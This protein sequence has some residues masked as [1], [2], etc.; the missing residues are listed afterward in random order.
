MKRYTQVILVIF[1]VLGL[2]WPALGEL[3]PVPTIRLQP[4]SPEKQEPALRQKVETVKRHY[5]Y[6][7]TSPL[8]HIVERGAIQPGLN[9]YGASFCMFQSPDGKMHFLA[10]F[11]GPGGWRMVH[12]NMSDASATMI[13]GNGVVEA[14]YC[15]DPARNVMY[16]TNKY[17]PGY[18]YI[19]NLAT[20]QVSL[21]AGPMWNIN[22]IIKG[23]DGM[24]WAGSSADGHIASY[25][26]VTRIFKTDWPKAH[27]DAQYIESLGAD[28]HYIYCGCRGKSDA[29]GRFLV[30][31]D[32]ANPHHI[33]TFNY[34]RGDVSANV[35]PGARDGKYYYFRREGKKNNYRTSY[36]A[37]PPVNGRL[38]QVSN[39]HM[40]NYLESHCASDGVRNHV[41]WER[42]Y[43]WEVNLDKYLPME[44]TQEYSEIKFRHPVGL[45]PWTTVSVPYTGP[46]GE[47]P[48]AAIIGISPTKVVS[49]SNYLVVY[50]YVKNIKKVKGQTFI[51]S[52]GIMRYDPTGEIYLLGYPKSTLRYDP[53]KPWTLVASNLKPYSPNDPNRP[54]PYK[55]A[56]VDSGHYHFAADYDANGLVWIAS[57]YTRTGSDYGVLVWYNPVDGTSGTVPGLEARLKLGAIKLRALVATNHRTKICV[58][59]ADG[60]IYVID[61]ATKTLEHTWT[62]RPGLFDAIIEVADDN[63][64]VVQAAINDASG[65]VSRVTKLRISTGDILFDHP[66]GVAGWAFGAQG[67]NSKQRYAW[68]LVK[69]PDDFGWMFVGD[70]LYRI[71]PKTGVFSKVCDMPYGKLVFNGADLAIYGC[72]AKEHRNHFLYF[73]KILTRIG[74]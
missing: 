39:P 23:T 7:L 8:P 24:I 38:T 15:Y 42:R 73:P 54:N 10:P 25:N 70:H 27:P 68:R 14:R 47:S 18:W 69:G 34:G 61:A 67:A 52:Y 32:R 66:I 56:L 36:Y 58:S 57:N 45:G 41:T 35:A 60:K 2:T 28:A 6:E 51:S 55:I 19:Y 21:L 11:D 22:G 46:W 44:G 29:L 64:L 53:T 13:S 59:G 43:H 1:V 31:I 3:P 71:D 37:L 33:M 63:L 72:H 26:P 62:L 16:L 5:K 48:N 4:V 49:L 40:D 17:G 74:H 12:V 65:N 50:D 20:N 30:V 9:S